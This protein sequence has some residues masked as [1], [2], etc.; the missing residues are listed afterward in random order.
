MGEQPSITLV[1]YVPRMESV[2]H[3]DC[4]ETVAC[5]NPYPSDRTVS[6]NHCNLPHRP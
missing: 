3:A 2:T 5:D 6:I 1:E 4:G